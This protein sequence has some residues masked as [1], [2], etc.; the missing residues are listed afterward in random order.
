MSIAISLIVDYLAIVVIAI[1]F[2]IF[3]FCRVTEVS[4]RVPLDIVFDVL[5]VFD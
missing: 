2:D 5:V 1:G 3:W 4:S